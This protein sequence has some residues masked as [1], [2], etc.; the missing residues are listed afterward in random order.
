MH[1]GMTVHTKNQ[2][3]HARVLFLFCYYVCVSTW[4]CHTVH[5]KVRRQL[6]ETVCSLHRAPEIRVRPSGLCD[7]QV[8]TH[9]IRPN[10]CQDPK[11]NSEHFLTRD[12]RLLSE[13]FYV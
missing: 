6:W 4:V 9:L 11:T 5:M 7:R 13:S 3:E 8:L 2:K 10:L 1:C 12:N